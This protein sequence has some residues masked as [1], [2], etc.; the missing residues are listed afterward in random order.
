MQQWEHAVYF[1][2]WYTTDEENVW[3]ARHHDSETYLQLPDLIRTLGSEGWEIVAAVPAVTAS[4]DKYV[5]GSGVAH[6]L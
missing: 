1:I 6:L 3:G 2:A 5:G 4:T